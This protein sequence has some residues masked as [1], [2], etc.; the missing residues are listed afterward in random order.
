MIV[1]KENKSKVITLKLIND[2]RKSKRLLSATACTFYDCESTIYDI[3][4]EVDIGDCDHGIMDVCKYIDM[5]ICSGL[6]T[7]DICLMDYANTCGTSYTDT[8][9]LD[10]I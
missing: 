1:T 6:Q 2:E 8:C 4:L 3:C 10:I 9:A 5:S 7:Q